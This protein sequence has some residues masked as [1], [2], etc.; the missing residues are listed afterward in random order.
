MKNIKISDF[1][2]GTTL[3]GFK[4]AFVK[5]AISP[6]KQYSEFL[7]QSQWWSA[8]DLREFQ[9]SELKRLLQLVY[10]HVPYYRGAMQVFQVKPK[11]VHSLEQLDVMPF[12]EKNMLRKRAFEF[13]STKSLAPA[14]HKCYTSGTTGT[15]LTVYRD[16]RNIG[17]EYA[18]LRRQKEWAGLADGERYATLKG[19]V[20]P[21]FCPRKNRYWQLNIAE[22]KLV[23]SSFHLAQETAERYVEALDKYQPA[24]IDGYPSSIYT[25]AKMMLQRG[26]TFPM[27][28]ILTSSETLAP[29]QKTVIEQAFACKVFD[30]YGMAERVAAI[31]TCE[32]GHYHV[33]PEYSIV[34][35]VRNGVLDDG[36]F[37][38]V[39]TALNNNAMPLI[40]Y[41]VGDIAELTDE[42]C[43]C[44]RAYPIIK[45]IVGRTDDSIITPSGKVVG[46]LDHIFKGAH[47]LVQA[48]I[49]QPEQDRIILRV[50]PDSTFSK[51]DSEF[52]LEKL[53]HRVG[54][55]IRFE[56]EQVPYIPRT[57][58]GKI[59]SVISKVLK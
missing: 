28:A 56:I 59:K 24:A 39:G 27:K 11:D 45:G 34:E 53:S 20:L 57:S 25:L 48:Q 21:D 58:R 26:I 7:D 35:F 49:Y 55:N 40:R 6:W 29:E 37:E 36:L 9:E 30:Y 19:E 51:K 42:T 41:R 12:V 32:H 23:M 13:L 2:L 5:R 18:M 52:V 8:Q 50:V 1:N 10:H 38:I 33:V 44:G 17:Y 46:R 47:N 54:E 14:L 3:N 4:H 15:P 31:H 16:L 22:N 43:T